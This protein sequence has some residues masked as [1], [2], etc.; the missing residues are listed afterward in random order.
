M[1]DSLA[2]LSRLEDAVRVLPGHMRPTTIGQERPWLDLDARE[3]RL[4]A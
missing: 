1:A 2:R 3:H 4:I